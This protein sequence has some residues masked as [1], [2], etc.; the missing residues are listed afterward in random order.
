[1]HDRVPPSL[2][3]PSLRQG[4]VSVPLI[5][6]TAVFVA[7]FFGGIFATL[8]LLAINARAADR[9]A[10]ARAPLIGGAVVAVLRRA[11]YTIIVGDFL[12]SMAF[13]ASAS[14][15]EKMQYVSANQSRT[16]RWGYRAV[17]LL[18]SIAL[19]MR[20]DKMWRTDTMSTAPTRSPW[21]PGIGAVLLGALIDAV[22]FFGFLS[23]F[24]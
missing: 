17:S 16:L 3:R 14:F 15:F 24:G 23:L 12:D 19:V 21:G 9:F 6:K 1:M 7:A 13:D 2:L 11:V 8:T 5:S 4:R 22:M 18:V 20:F 10:Q